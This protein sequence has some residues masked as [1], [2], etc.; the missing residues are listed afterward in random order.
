[1]LYCAN[2]Q[3]TA[4]H[5]LG[6]SSTGLGFHRKPW[7]RQNRGG[8]V[9]ARGAG[10]RRGSCLARGHGSLGGNVADE[11]DR[12]ARKR[13]TGPHPGIIRSL[14]TRVFCAVDVPL[15][16]LRSDTVDGEAADR[17]SR[18]SCLAPADRER[19]TQQYDRE[20]AQR[21]SGRAVSPL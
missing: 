12:R 18:G 20:G 3:E 8:G 16:G 11:R 19:G 7:G 14:A 2:Q 1:M 5:V 17:K 21:E 15:T 6:Q 13:R 10:L 9:T 4:L